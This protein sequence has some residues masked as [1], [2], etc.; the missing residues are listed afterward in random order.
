M[1]NLTFFGRLVFNMTQY[2]LLLFVCSFW[3][4]ELTSGKCF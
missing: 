2:K 3:T 1:N 4:L